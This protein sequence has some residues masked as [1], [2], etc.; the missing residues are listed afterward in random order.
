MKISELKE[1]IQRFNLSD[2]TEIALFKNDAMWEPDLFISE[3]EQDGFPVGSIII[4]GDD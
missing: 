4:N 3:H 1:F 2:E